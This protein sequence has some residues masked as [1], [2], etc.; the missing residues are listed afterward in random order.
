MTKTAIITDSNSG[1]LEQ[2]AECLGIYTVPMPVVIEGQVYYEGKNLTHAQF[3][4]QLLKKK[5]IS[6]SQPAPADVIT[7]WE[8][9]FAEGFEEVVYIP[10][11][12]GLSNSYQTAAMLAKQYGN[13]V[14]VVDN[15]R[16]SV[17][18]RYSVED[19][20]LLAKAGLRG[21]EIKKELERQ[22]YRSLIYVGVDSLDYLKQGGRITTAAAAMGSFLNLKPL[23]TI[24]GE[25]LDAYAKVRGTK[26]CK[27]R[28]L[29]AMQ[30]SVETYTKRNQ[31]VHIGAAGSF[32]QEE[33]QAEWLEMIADKFAGQVVHYDPLTC[34]IGCHVGPGAFGMG[35]SQTLF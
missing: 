15:H 19:G 31:S 25:R 2:E 1:I 4:Q 28:L 8:R 34:S 5:Q 13:R 12:S 26:Q 30:Q 35:I 33:E 21:S 29:D 23:L 27:K 9:A 3:Y 7:V 20:I 32:L 6:T 17:T 24:K 16:I 18:Q 22:A 11:S 14:S 10:M